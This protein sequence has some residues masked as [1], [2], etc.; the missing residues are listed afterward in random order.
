MKLRKNKLG[1][2]YLDILKSIN[3]LAINYSEA[4][5]RLETL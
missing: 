2:N 5:R 1:S 3:N 4:R